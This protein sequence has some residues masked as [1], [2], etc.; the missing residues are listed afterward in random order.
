M[1]VP[2]EAVSSTNPDSSGTGSAGGGTNAL[3]I[4]DEACSICEVWASNL[5][6]EFHGIVQVVQRCNCVAMNTKFLGIVTYPNEEFRRTA[7][8]QYQLL[9]CGADIFKITQLGLTFIDACG[10]TFLNFPRG[11]S[12]SSSA[13][14][15]IRMRR[16][17]LTC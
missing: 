14:R 15:R 17:L 16:G 3:L 13:S 8:Y 7:D 1:S 11:S 10:N 4:Y 12:I 2:S 5:N 6:E 9:R